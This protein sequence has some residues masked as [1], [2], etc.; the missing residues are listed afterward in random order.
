MTKMTWCRSSRRAEHE[1]D[2]GREGHSCGMLG[3]TTEFPTNGTLVQGL[4]SLYGV[5]VAA[6]VPAL[7]QTWAKVLHLPRALP[8]RLFS[9]C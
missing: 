1:P 7:E 8:P 4:E 3:E 5:L 6:Y 9:R 2:L